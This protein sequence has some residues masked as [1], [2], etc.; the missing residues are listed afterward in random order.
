M[1]GEKVRGGKGGETK[2]SERYKIT[3]CVWTSEHSFYMLLYVKGEG[4]RSRYTL[5]CERER[6]ER[7]WNDSRRR[8]Q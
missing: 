6:D 8:E 7:H 1:R 3:V 5:L 4:R 2:L